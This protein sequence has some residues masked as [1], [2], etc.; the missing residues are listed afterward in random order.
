MKPVNGLNELNGPH[1]NTPCEIE[2]CE[3]GDGGAN[4]CGSDSLS[5]F[6]LV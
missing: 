2:C 3:G 5:Y 4:L 6:A 1:S